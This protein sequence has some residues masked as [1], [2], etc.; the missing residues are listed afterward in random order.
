[1][2]DEF[3]KRL[4]DTPLVDRKVEHPSDIFVGNNKQRNLQAGLKA[5]KFGLA[6]DRPTTPGK[7]SH[8]FAYFS[9]DTFVFSCWSGSAWKTT[10]LS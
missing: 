10:T 6:A 2:P 9:L 3:G 1:M 4:E 7:D 8:F 5:I